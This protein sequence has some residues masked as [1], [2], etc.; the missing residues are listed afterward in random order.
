MDS[1]AL[2]NALEQ[3]H[4]ASFGWA[5]ACCGQD[6]AQAE[7]VLQDVYLKVLQGRAVYRGRAAFL[8]WLFAI[9]RNTAA[10]QRRRAWWRQGWLTRYQARAERAPAERCP[11]E[12]LEQSQTRTWFR[13]ALQD[14][15]RRQREVLHLVFYQDLSVAEAA[16]AMGVSVGSARRHYDRGK[17]AL[18]RRLAEEQCFDEI[19][20]DRAA[21]QGAVP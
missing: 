6:P 17:Q 1:Q 14:L 13:A 4:R 7:E 2:R 21:A 19:R 11:D 9:I 16:E 15:P 5:L 18:R 8:T 20:L 3:H 10:E 12:A